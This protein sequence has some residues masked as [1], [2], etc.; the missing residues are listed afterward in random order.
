MRIAV[1][2]ASGNI[3][4]ALLRRIAAPDSGHEVVG[5]ARRPPAPGRDPVYDGVEWHAMDLATSASLP[6]LQEAFEG[7]DAVVHLVWV[8]QP[9]R[10]QKYIHDLDLGGTR[11]VLGAVENAGVG[12]LVHLSSIGAYS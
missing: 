1:T 2:G 5:I 10:R 12:H 4:T 9:S 3:G 8:L 11:R 6:R 7:V